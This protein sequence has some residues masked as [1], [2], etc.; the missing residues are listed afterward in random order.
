MTRTRYKIFDS[1]YPYFLT[2][3]IVDWLPIFADPN[4]AGIL[5]NA[6]RFM[7]D[8]KRARLF[9]YVLMENHLHCIVQSDDLST[10][11]KSF[12]SYTARA[13]IDLLEEHHNNDLLKKL[14]KNKLHHKTFSN[15]Q[16]WQESS[17]PQEI[18]T[19]EMMRQKVEYIHNNPVRRG[20]VDEACDWR[21]SSARNYEGLQGLITIQTEW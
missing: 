5:I 18:S 20:Y 2:M 14:K 13:I 11:V 12:K 15:Y 9:A 7:Q 17:H 1:A 4:I 8:V 6:L 3:T 21:Y 19:D 16:L 10:V